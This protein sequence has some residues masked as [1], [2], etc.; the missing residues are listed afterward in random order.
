MTET[1]NVP[2]GSFSLTRLPVRRNELLRA[3]DAADEYL[4][5]SVAE[6]IP[7]CAASRI[8]VVNDSF[9]ALAVAL[10]AYQPQAWSDSYLSQQATRLNLR[11]NGWPEEAVQLW[12]SLQTPLGSFD[13]VLIKAPKTLALLEDLLLRL[14]PH[15]TR[16]THI[17]VA[18]MLKHLP[19]SVWTLLERLI[20]ST[21]TALARKKARLIFVT[22]DPT[23]SVPCNPYPSTYTLEN[24]TYQISNH[25][26]V[27]SREQLDIGTRFFLQHLPTHTSAQTI[28][29]LGCGNGVLGLIA[30]ERNPQA[31][32]IF[33]DES[34]MAIASARENFMAAFGGQQA[35][36][37]SVGD[38][39][40]DFASGSVD[41]I[42]CNPPFHQ[43]QAVGDQLAL[44]LFRQAHKALKLQGALWVIG[45]RHL[46]YQSNL[47]KLFGN[48]TLIAAN[49]KFVIL[50]ALR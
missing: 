40:Q 26:N 5:N 45:N 35:A 8:L 2:Q 43:Q 48:C 24:T 38:G 17:V 15:L 42:L 14:R 3:W 18:G 22:L 12:D 27:F 19:A 32:I 16:T 41:L 36:M 49:P 46:G 21:T 37:F 34:F 9:G 25:A 23:L 47:Q 50:K 11:M 31:K 13:V 1:L 4:L 20:G 44:S 33:A 7:L 10:A 29:D 28:V 30:A 6:H 39:L